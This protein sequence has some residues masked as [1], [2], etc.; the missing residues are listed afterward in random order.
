MSRPVYPYP[1][2]AVY[3]GFGDPFVESSFIEKVI[4]KPLKRLLH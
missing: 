4:Y 1:R 3:D 2:I